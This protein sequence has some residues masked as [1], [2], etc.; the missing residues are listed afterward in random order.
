M[1]GWLIILW[2]SLSV[3]GGVRLCVCVYVF[4]CAECTSGKYSTGD[5]VQKRVLWGLQAVLDLPRPD[6]P[7]LAGAAVAP[8]PDPTRELTDADHVRITF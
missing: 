5:H 4:V 1:G 3:G 6:I 8:G 7:L 2:P